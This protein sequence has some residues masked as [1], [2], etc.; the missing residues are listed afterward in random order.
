MLRI[1]TAVATKKLL[2]LSSVHS[3]KIHR[4]ANNCKVTNVN[5]VNSTRYA[6]AR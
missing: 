3:V 4:L 1:S 2:Q 5:N 6:A